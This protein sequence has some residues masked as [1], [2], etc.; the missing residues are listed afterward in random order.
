MRCP[1]SINRLDR[2]PHGQSAAWARYHAQR[3]AARE[4]GEHEPEFPTAESCGCWEYNSY[5]ARA[6]T[7][8]PDCGYKLS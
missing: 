5:L 8:V 7:T 2:S 6:K 3:Y 4:G 1:L